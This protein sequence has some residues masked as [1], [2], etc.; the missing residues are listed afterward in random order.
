[1]P[2]S[3]LGRLGLGGGR[4]SSLLVRK[5][6]LV[7]KG[8]ISLC[9]K[10]TRSPARRAKAGSAEELPAVSSAPECLEGRVSTVFSHGGESRQ[11]TRGRPSPGAPQGPPQLWPWSA[12]PRLELLLA[13]WGPGLGLPTVGREVWK[14]VCRGHPVWAQEGKECDRGRVW[15]R[16]VQP[17]VGFSWG[18]DGREQRRSPAPSAPATHTRTLLQRGCRAGAQGH[19]LEI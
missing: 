5:D 12:V 18:P 11:A 14:P 17:V 10:P 9:G 15:L 4:G 2:I 8:S 3:G 19:P 6:P 1:M 16:G 7:R 13:P